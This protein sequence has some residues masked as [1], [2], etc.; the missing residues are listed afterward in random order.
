MM[1]NSYVAFLSVSFVLFYRNIIALISIIIQSI[2]KCM[3]ILLYS[4]I[5][6]ELVHFNLSPPIF[7]KENICDSLQVG[8]WC[9][10]D[11]VSTSSR[12]I[13]VYAMSSS[14]RHV[15]AAGMFSFRRTKPDLSI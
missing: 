6:C 8:K 9:Q 14:L 3:R 12:R 15:P 5:K 11:V 2:S 10:N 4:Y 1:I 7:A 13:V